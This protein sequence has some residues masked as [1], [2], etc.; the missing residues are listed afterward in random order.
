MKK[1]KKRSN[2][3]GTISGARAREL[4]TPTSRAVNSP[5]SSIRPQNVPKALLRP[6]AVIAG[7]NREVG[8]VSRGEDTTDGISIIFSKFSDLR[9]ED[10]LAFHRRWL[11]VLRNVNGSMSAS[12]N[13]PGGYLNHVEDAF[14]IAGS[15]F[16]VASVSSKINLEEA[17]ITLYFHDI[18]RPV[19]YARSQGLS[20]PDGIADTELGISSGGRQNF[21]SE[22]LPQLGIVLN[23]REL[24]ALRYFHEVDR[25][26]AVKLVAGE[27]LA[28]FCQSC[29]VLSHRKAESYKIALR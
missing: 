4:F 9:A 8:V 23:E 15:L 3:N 21:Y 1:R 6:G 2:I 10:L 20:L 29:D 18:E 11:P 16:Q 25:L 5:A 26:A 12:F 14:E 24:H 17:Y 13:W 7:G 22:V 28:G 19:R 27:R